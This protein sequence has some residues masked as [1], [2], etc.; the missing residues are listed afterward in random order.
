MSC[1]DRITECN[2]C[3]FSNYLPFYITQKQVGWIHRQHVPLLVQWPKTFTLTDE[4][5]YLSEA[6][7]TLRKRTHALAVTVRKLR[8]HQ[9]VSLY[10][11]E[12]CDVVSAWGEPPLAAIERSVAPFFGLQTYGTHLN[13][14]VRKN[15]KLYLWLAR[16]SPCDAIAPDQLD[17]IAAGGLPIGTLP[18]INIT[19]EAKTEAGVPSILMQQATAQGS[20]FYCL[21]TH[22]G[23]TPDT[24][25]VYDL[26]L[27]QDFRPVPDGKEIVQFE[28]LPAEK[29][30]DI[31]SRPDRVKYNSAL[32][33]IDFLIRHH[34]LVPSYPDY[35][36]IIKKLYLSLPNYCLA[37][38]L[39]V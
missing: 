20:I 33:M 30:L 36:R 19:R 39:A 28:L 38:Q 11:S 16:R 10:H 4:A 22:A 14:Y 3:D 8:A 34:I 9:R 15:N 7:N 12:L 23:I 31:V 2:R 17:N 37:N 29:V 18:H 21:E 27:P 24:M 13:G 5:V 25:F 1:L 6:L 32:V 26:E 35:D